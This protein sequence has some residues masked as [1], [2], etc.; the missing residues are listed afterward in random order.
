MSTNVAM[1]MTMAKHRTTT[2]ESNN[3]VKLIILVKLCWSVNDNY[4]GKEHIQ[5]EAITEYINIFIYT[6][7]HT[8]MLTHAH[9][10]VCTYVHTNIYICM[11]VCM[12][13][14]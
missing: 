2:L 6:Y 12:V 7:I 11:N 3:W 14:G 4:T 1:A 5:E 8:Y 10:Y 9:M 13:M